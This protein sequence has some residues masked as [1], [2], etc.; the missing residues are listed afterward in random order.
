MDPVLAWIRECRAF[1]NDPDEPR[2]EDFFFGTAEKK[3]EKKKNKRKK[4][5]EQTN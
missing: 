2:V 5:D 4:K 3:L 1:H